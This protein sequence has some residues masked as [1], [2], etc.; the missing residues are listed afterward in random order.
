MVEVHFPVKI[1][2]ASSSMNFDNNEPLVVMAISKS[3]SKLLI[4]LINFMMSLRSNGSPPVIL[5]FFSPKGK[6]A[7]TI[8]LI[9]SKD[10][11]LLRGK[12]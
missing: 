2:P 9:C 6:M 4:I 5:T 3:E 1:D 7:F 12:N 8:L 10:K 11:I